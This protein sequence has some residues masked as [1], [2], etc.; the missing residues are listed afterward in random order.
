MTFGRLMPQNTLCG[1]ADEL[2][3]LAA[4]DRARDAA[5]GTGQAAPPKSVTMNMALPKPPQV[6][7]PRAP[8]PTPAINAPRFGAPPGLKKLRLS[9]TKLMLP[10]LP[11]TKPRMPRAWQRPGVQSR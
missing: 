4:T 7:L 9:K 8:K 6:R 11:A 2:Y 3:K 1:F 10:R 5:V